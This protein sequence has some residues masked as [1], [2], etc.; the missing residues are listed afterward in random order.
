MLHRAVDYTD[1]SDDTEQRGGSVE[2][3][4]A[5]WKLM[6]KVSTVS[7]P[8][9]SYQDAC[10]ELHLDHM[11]PRL[12]SAGG[13]GV[14]LNPWQVIGVAWA[15]S[16][17]AGPCRGGVIADACGIGKTIQMLGVISESVSIAQRRAEYVPP[18]AR[19][20]DGWL[21]TRQ[22]RRFDGRLSTHLGALPQ[23]RDR[24]L[25]HGDPET[26]PCPEGVSMV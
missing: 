10:D 8:T 25:V 18:G 11:E 6:N 22:G 19:D 5:F 4:Q 16:Q 15:M 20:S 23:R 3:D 13:D 2:L 14:V 21:T 17:E 26:F 24:S 1:T 9:P 7:A 12:M